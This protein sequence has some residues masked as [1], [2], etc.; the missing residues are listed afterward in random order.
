MNLA[1]QHNILSALTDANASFGDYRK[2]IIDE[3]K[4]Q[5]LSTNCPHRHVCFVH[6]KEIYSPHFSRMDQVLALT[7]AYDV[8]VD[9]SQKTEEGLKFYSTLFS[10]MNGLGEAVEAIETACEL[11]FS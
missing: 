11:Y 10:M 9:V 3:N 6:V 8:Y 5:V 7:A 2:K 1:A 4:R